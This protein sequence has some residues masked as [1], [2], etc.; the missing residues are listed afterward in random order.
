MKCFSHKQK[1]L[2]FARIKKNKDNAK[3][4]VIVIQENNIC[5]SI[6]KDKLN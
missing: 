3:E 1:F 2:Q 5:W 6:K 4:K